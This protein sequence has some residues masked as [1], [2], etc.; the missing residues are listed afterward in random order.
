M[1]PLFCVPD[2]ADGAAPSRAPRNRPGSRRPSRRPAGR[3]APAK[4][5]ADLL[6][7]TAEWLRRALVR[8]FLRYSVPGDLEAAVHAVMNVVE[9][10]LAARDTEILRLRGLIGARGRGR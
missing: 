3:T 9:P 10:V 5:T 4:E 8:S 1:T 7:V 2:I 6:A